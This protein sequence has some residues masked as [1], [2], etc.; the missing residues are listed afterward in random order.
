MKF[1]DPCNRIVSF[2]ESR[3]TPKSHFWAC[4]WRPHTSLKVGLRH[5]PPLEKKINVLIDT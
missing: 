2:R 5:F 4:E 3:R 1:F